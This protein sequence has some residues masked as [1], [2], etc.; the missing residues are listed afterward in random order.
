MVDV[1]SFVKGLTSAD[2]CD[3]R[4]SNEESASTHRALSVLRVERVSN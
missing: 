2:Q 4:I 3:R 1:R